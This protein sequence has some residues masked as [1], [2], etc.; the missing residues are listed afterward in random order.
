MADEVEQTKKKKSFFSKVGSV[1][2][3]AIGLVIM[4]GSGTHNE[5]AGFTPNLFGVTGGAKIK[6]CAGIPA[7]DQL[8]ANVCRAL[9]IPKHNG[10][11]K[12]MLPVYDFTEDYRDK[13]REENK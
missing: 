11:T 1:S 6:K 4:S 9:Y 7:P 2:V 5:A 13:L 12:G 3:S 10:S 8:R